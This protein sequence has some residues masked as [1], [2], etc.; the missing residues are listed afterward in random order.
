MEAIILAGGLG[1]RLKPV[2]HDI[3]KSMAIVNHRPFLEYLMDFLITQEINQVVLSVGYKCEFIIQHFGNQYKSLKI[4]YAV[5]KEPLGTGGGIRL[6]FWKIEGV[7][8]FILNGDS[9]FRID[10]RK[11]LSDHLRKKSTATIAL[12]KLEHTGRYGRVCI[13]R[14]KRIISFQE[15]NEQ[16]IPGYINGG[17][18]IIEKASLMEPE[19]RGKFSIETDFFESSYRENKMF[20]FP[21]EAYFLDIGIPEDYKKAQHDFAGF[22]D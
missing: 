22:K 2:V 5:E 20:G 16:D 4:S 9:F 17:I 14:N 11:M 6:A 13:N 15:K 18:Y 1:T 10:Y 7:R 3:P 21:S 8:A 19:F 12:R